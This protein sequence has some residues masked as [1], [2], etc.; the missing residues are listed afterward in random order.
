MVWNS[1][2]HNLQNG[3]KPPPLS[4]TIASFDI[5]V[6]GCIIEPALVCAA[7]IGERHSRCGLFCILFCLLA[8][9]NQS[10]LHAR[11]A[12][13]IAPL[14]LN[15]FGDTIIF[16]CTVTLI[17][18]CAALASEWRDMPWHIF[19]FVCPLRVASSIDVDLVTSS[20]HW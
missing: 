2:Q 6:V 14:P 13:L 1:K 7:Q 20:S 9:T 15:L 3:T 5:I 10:L 4:F 8:S 19:F 11:Q 12:K 17:Q 16:G 18:V